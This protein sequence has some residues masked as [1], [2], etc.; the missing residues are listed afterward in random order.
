[1]ELCELELF[2][3]ELDDWL[4]ALDWLRLDSELIELAEL[5]RLLELE[6]ELELDDWLLAELVRLLLEL[7]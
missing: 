2:E 3:L 6:L 4:L 1:M 5:V 7:D